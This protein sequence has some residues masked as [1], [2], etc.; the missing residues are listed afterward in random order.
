MTGIFVYVLAATATYASGIEA[1]E[2]VEVDV[3]ASITGLSKDPVLFVLYFIM[4]ALIA[5]HDNT[6]ATPATAVSFTIR[7][8]VLDFFIF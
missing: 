7:L 1:V 3:S 8:F 6:T 5:A 4:C 2:A